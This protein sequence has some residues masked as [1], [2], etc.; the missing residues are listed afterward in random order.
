MSSNRENEGDTGAPDASHGAGDQD[1]LPAVQ[2]RGTAV[3]AVAV[4]AEVTSRPSTP[5]LVGDAA[6]ASEDGQP[7]PT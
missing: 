4:E 2:E 3:A 1:P 5:E 6:E 7:E